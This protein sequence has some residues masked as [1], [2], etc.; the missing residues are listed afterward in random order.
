MPFE[1]V[2]AVPE[3]ELRR[4]AETLPERVW[5]SEAFFHVRVDIV[6]GSPATVQV[7]SPPRGLRAVADC[8]TDSASRWAWPPPDDDEPAQ[9]SIF[10]TVETRAQPPVVVP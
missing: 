6:P 4:C 8:L 5:P 7:I 1:V 3:G 2:A 10:V 9:A